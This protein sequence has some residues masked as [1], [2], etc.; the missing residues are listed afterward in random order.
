VFVIATA[1]AVATTTA[2]HL[3]STS[4]RALRVEARKIQKIT[5]ACCISGSIAAALRQHCSS[6]QRLQ[7]HHI[8]NC[9]P[10]LELLLLLL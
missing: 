3:Y 8:G 9:P 1:V 5:T 4:E 6:T 7:Q 10:P 2:I